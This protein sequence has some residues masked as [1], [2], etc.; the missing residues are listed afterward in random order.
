MFEAP[1]RKASKGTGTG[2]G[3][4][5]GGGAGVVTPKTGAE[6]TPASTGATINSQTNYKA[7]SAANDRKTVG[8]NEQVDF[9]VDNTEGTYSASAGTGTSATKGTETTFTWT[10]QATAG[11]ATITFTPKGG[12]T[13]TTVAMKVVAPELKFT[14]TGPL[15]GITGVGAGMICDVNFLPYDVCFGTGIQWEEGTAPASNA[16]GFFVGLTLDGHVPAAARAFDNNN[17]GPKDKASFTWSQ[18]PDKD[19][20]YDWVIPQN[21]VIGGTK[22]LIRNVTQTCQM[23]GPPHAGRTTV[24]KDGTETLTRDP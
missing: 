2:T 4:G 13:V 8:V 1:E 19:G 17:A 21:Y 14:K 10:A 22:Y 7:K 18:K 23:Y 9:W 3:E 20:S 15:G 6:A 12:G 16:Q 5:A 24:T 11:A